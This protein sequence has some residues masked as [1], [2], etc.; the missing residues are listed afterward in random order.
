MSAFSNRF[1]K[2]KEDSCLTLKELSE[3][4][5]ITVPNLSYYMNGREPNYDTLIKIAD[6]FDV[7]LDW[8][9]GR[10]YFQFEG[11]VYMSELIE[12]RLEIES[13]NALDDCALD[14]F[15]ATSYVTLKMLDQFY[16]F[17]KKYYDFLDEEHN[18]LIDYPILAFKEFLSTFV[19]LDLDKISS[20]KLREFLML[21]NE[22]SYDTEIF[23]QMAYSDFTKQLAEKSDLSSQDK[24]LIEQ[25][26]HVINMQK[27]QSFDKKS[28]DKLYG[29]LNAKVE[30]FTK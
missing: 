18:V 26:I 13:E 17:Y 9:L 4:L 12:Q 2:L 3:K 22:L 21:N 7:T 8:L 16:L 25:I 19:S 15:E 28:I 29:E 6:Y 24:L 11:S 27:N 10:S 23:M 5:D 30:D 14:A 20:D 1:K